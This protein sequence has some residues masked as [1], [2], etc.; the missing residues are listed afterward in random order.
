MLSKKAVRVLVRGTLQSA[1]RI[2]EVDLDVGCH[3]ELPARG[4]FWSAVE[5]NGSAKWR[6]K[7]ANL[8]AY[9]LGYGPETIC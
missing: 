7:I 4:E 6:G 3:G 5:R 9:R 8:P 1:L 2:A